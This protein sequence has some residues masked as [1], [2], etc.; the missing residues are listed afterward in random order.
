MAASDTIQGDVVVSNS[1][2]LA[3]LSGVK[4]ITGDLSF[5]PW[6]ELTSL[7]LPSLQ[8]VGSFSVS[9]YAL[10]S[11]SLPA[12]TTVDNDLSVEDD[13]D[14]LATLDFGALTAVGGSFDLYGLQ[15][16]S[17]TA[18]SHLATIGGD[19]SISS[20][21]FTT[22]APLAGAFAGLSATSSVAVYYND[23]LVDVS[24]LGSLKSVV[25]FTFT[26]NAAT[27]LELTSLTSTNLFNVA[28]NAFSSFAADALTTVTGEFFLANNGA[29][30]TASLTKLASVASF[31]VYGD[32]S[33]KSLSIPALATVNGDFVFTGNGL[34]SLAANALTTV[35]GNIGIHDSS[36]GDTSA[37]ASV[38]FQ[39]LA[40]IGSLSIANEPK[41][42]SAL[43]LPL[44][45]SVTNGIQVT[46]TAIPS[47]AA[48]A[49]TSFGD[50]TYL[51]SN[52]ALTSVSFAKLASTQY[53]GFQSNT[54]LASV[55]LPKLATVSSE[56]HFDSN[57][58]TSLSFP[59]L[60]S[61]TGSLSITSNNSLTTLVTPTL[62]I[63]VGG[64]LQIQSNSVLPECQAD[65][66]DQHVTASYNVLGS[67]GGTGL[68]N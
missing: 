35:T 40:T 34:P 50:T 41:L 30:T 14:V 15:L 9:A 67:N 59:A 32:T 27:K 29:L 46:N 7:S 60:T 55:A 65:A 33:M 49:V 63:T 54:A 68:C 26:G 58:V 61:V 36:D 21:A 62:P 5:N 38:S 22:L 19:V 47:F 17:P 56:L 13:N 11:V 8:R 25:N 20:T 39:K 18:F 42:A 24:A 64:Y 10:T 37:L 2:Q 48:D 4:T 53:L 66:F 44:L 51:E 43:S 31:R 45:A 12:L 52:G 3:M 1:L 28:Q 23:S 57:A 6:P 16:A